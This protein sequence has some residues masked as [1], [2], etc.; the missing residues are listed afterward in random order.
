MEVPVPTTTA[1]T[2]TAQRIE[3]RREGRR[4]WPAFLRSGP[5]RLRWVPASLRTRIL[6]WFIGVLALATA[7]SVLVTYRVLSV[8]VDQRISA[9]LGQEAAELRKLAAGNDPQTGTPFGPRVG[10]I[11]Q[12]YLARNVPSRNEALITFLNGEPFKRS[13]YVVPYQLDKDPEIIARWANVQ[14]SQRGRVETPAG[15][16]EY[17]AVPLRVKERGAF[18]TRGVFVA[19]I[20]A[21]RARAD[22]SSV[23]RAAGAVG[24]GLLVLGSLLAWRLADRVVR[25][26]TALTR[27]VRTISATDLGERVPVR[28]RDQVALLASTFN[29]MLDRLEASFASQRRFVDDASHELKTPLTIVR[30]HLELLD[31]DTPDEREATLSLV[32]DELD[33]MTRIVEDLLL[34]ANHGRP[35]FLALGPV[36]VGSLSEDL[37]AKAKALAARDWVLEERGHGTIVADRHRLT[38]AVIQLA[39]N[40]AHHAHGG[41]PIAL[42]S[43]VADGEARF[44]VRDQGPGIKPEEQEAIFERFRRGGTIRVDGAG[45]GLAIVKA[46]AEAHDGRVE[47]ESRFGEGTTF[48]VVIPTGHDPDGGAR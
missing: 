27:R 34:L 9:E 24:L 47:L 3:P 18:E 42:G 39:Q 37:H 30:G 1:T 40:A 16:V 22:V 43:R 32:M 7:S 44:W 17:L 5:A 21:E 2:T 11:L 41:A 20:F 12:V 36:D 35:D 10:R 46:I 31:E 14:Q 28:G 25:P 23:L 45:L 38:Q 13:A 48:T 19:A 8:R 4:P 15:R 33:R 6:A 26:V 29:E